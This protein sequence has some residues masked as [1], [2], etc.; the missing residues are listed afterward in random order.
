M[1]SGGFTVKGSL[2][3]GVP[4]VVRMPTLWIPVVRKAAGIVTVIWV[5]PEELNVVIADWSHNTQAT[6]TR[7]VPLIVRLKAPVPAVRLV[8]LRLVT[9]SAG[10]TV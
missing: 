1:V 5:D 10:K 3:D 4:S 2:L 9:T 6:F 7:F 8:G